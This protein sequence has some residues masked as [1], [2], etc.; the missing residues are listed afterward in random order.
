MPAMRQQLDAQARE[1]ALLTAELQAYRRSGD[2]DAAV[3]WLVAENTRL[4]AHLDNIAE[5]AE[6]TNLQAV[7]GHVRREVREAREGR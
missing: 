6:A 7:I 3:R 5:Y 2:Q 1:I 4:A